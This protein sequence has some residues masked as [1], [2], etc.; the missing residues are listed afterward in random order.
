L[1]PHQSRF[2]SL[3][4]ERQFGIGRVGIARLG[5]RYRHGVAGETLWF[6]GDWPRMFS[7]NVAMGLMGAD[8]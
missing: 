4:A 2:V 8:R 3:Y 6:G 1:G 7:L 5:L